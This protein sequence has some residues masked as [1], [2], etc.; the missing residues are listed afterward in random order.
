LRVNPGFYKADVGLGSV[1][2]EEQNLD[3]AEVHLK[4]ALNK[5]PKDPGVREMLARIVKAKAESKP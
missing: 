5:N 1:S 4:S 2:I 3:Q